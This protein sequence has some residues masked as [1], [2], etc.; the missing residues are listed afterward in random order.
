M[1]MNGKFFSC[2]TNHTRKKYFT[3][4]AMYNK[5][6]NLM[7]VMT[8]ICAPG[9]LTLIKIRNSLLK[10]LL[11]FFKHDA[12]GKSCPDTLSQER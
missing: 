12:A 11:R 2:N 5:S 7:V 10:S 9:P 8:I 1:N 6:G 3:S 4:I